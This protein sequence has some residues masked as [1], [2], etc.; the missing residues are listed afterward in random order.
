[1]LVT[2][3]GY[4]NPEG[5]SLLVLILVV[6]V[7]YQ[8]IRWL[9]ATTYYLETNNLIPV[10]FFDFLLSMMI[11]VVA[12]NAS[13]PA[14]SPEMSEHSLP[15][16]ISLIK[17]M[18]EAM[19]AASGAAFKELMLSIMPSLINLAVIAVGILA[20]LVYGVIL[21][22]RHLRA[23]EIPA[24]ELSDFNHVEDEAEFV[25]GDPDDHG[26]KTAASKQA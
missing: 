3:D 15:M 10:I 20:M 16:V 19:S 23:D 17:S 24:D 13:N 11:A 14:L 7:V 9:Y 6:T 12:G 5:T 2:A 4:A 8:I 25:F 21:F 1:M 26:R 22:V 18:S